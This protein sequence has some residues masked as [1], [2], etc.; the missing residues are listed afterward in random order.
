[1][2][3]EIKTILK[4][5]VNGLI[6]DWDTRDTTEMVTTMANGD[7]VTVTV[8]IEIE[9]KLPPCK[10]CGNSV[11]HSSNLASTHTF[12]CSYCGYEVVFKLS[13]SEDSADLYRELVR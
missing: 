8:L 11:E 13:T 7:T 5:S 10:A 12:S 1:M 4:E 2:R 3:D 6:A 9:E